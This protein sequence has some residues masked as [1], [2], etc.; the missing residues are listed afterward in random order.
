MLRVK[1]FLCFLASRL[2]VFSSF[3]SSMAQQL[4]ALQQLSR[5]DRHLDEISSQTSSY[6]ALY[7]DNIYGLLYS[8]I[9]KT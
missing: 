9:Y 8:Y 6:E 7:D 4:H 1:V 3:I 5:A 2:C